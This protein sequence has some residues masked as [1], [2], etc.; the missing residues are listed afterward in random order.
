MTIHLG[1]IGAT[2]AFPDAH[3]VTILRDLI[4]RRPREPAV[5][6]FRLA[7]VGI[8]RRR[9]VAHGLVQGVFFRDSCRRIAEQHGVSGW[10]RN[11]YDGAVEA[12]FEGADDSVDRLVSWAR[13]GPSRAIVE[14]LDVSSEEP[15]GLA[16]FRVR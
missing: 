2:H 13:H 3:R 6:S 7:Q 12:V 15:E 14:R 10:V 11:R 5:P 16:S 4:D 9:I 8:I 1:S